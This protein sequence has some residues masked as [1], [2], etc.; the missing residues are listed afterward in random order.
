MPKPD[1]HWVIAIYIQRKLDGLGNADP[2]TVN[3]HDRLGG[4]RATFTGCSSQPIADGFAAKRFTAPG[5]S[6]TDLARRAVVL[7]A[8][9]AV[10]S[11]HLGNF[12]VMTK[13]RYETLRARE[14]TNK[15]DSRAITQRYEPRVKMADLQK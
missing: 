2:L 5:Y 8:V 13:P 1:Q 12:D 4:C 7:R 9:A 11:A 10:T 14:G 3:N 15:P 6:S